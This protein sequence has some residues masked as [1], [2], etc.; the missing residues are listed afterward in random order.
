MMC[1]ADGMSPGRVAKFD[2][3]LNLAGEQAAAVFSV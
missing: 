2:G 1:A 3:N